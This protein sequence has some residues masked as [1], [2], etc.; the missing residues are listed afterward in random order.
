MH[1]RNR[2]R[3]LDG[4][5]L[6]E[7]LVVVSIIA[8][9]IAIMLPSMRNA[10]EA[11]RRAVCAS[12]EHQFGLALT[13]Y[14]AD[15]KNYFLPMFRS[16]NA[17]YNYWPQA[18][19]DIQTKAFTTRYGLPSDFLKCPSNQVWYAQAAGGGWP[20][21]HGGSYFYMGNPQ[22]ASTSNS[23]WRDPAGIPY[24]TTS[25]ASNSGGLLASDFVYTYFHPLPVRTVYFACHSS[26][27]WEDHVNVFDFKDFAGAN[28]LFTDCHVS[29]KNAGSY[30]PNLNADGAGF[31]NANF[32]YATAGNNSAVYW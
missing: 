29:W 12:N 7:L 23:F 5:T 1:P 18:Y 17:P 8:M 15:N 16:L 2:F 20:D 26:I 21:N 10:R 3:K 30:L 28:Q 32:V 14:A 11:A 6:I 19:E 27:T 13:V 24:K 25:P 9:L 31:G 4:F 22:Y